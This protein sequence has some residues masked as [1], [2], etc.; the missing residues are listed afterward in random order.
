MIDDCPANGEGA[1]FYLQAFR[2]K[3]VLITGGLGFIGSNL[4]R[5][6]LDLGAEVLIVDSLIPEYGGNLFNVA[7]FADRVRINIADVRDRSSMD[8]LVQGQDYLFN[9][10]GQVS[11]LDSMKDPFTDLE[12]NCRSQ[13]SILESCRYNNPGVKVVFASTR[14]IYG[15]P[16]YLPVDERHLLHPTDVNGINKMAGEWYHIVYNNAYGLRATSLRLTNTFGPG[17]RAR[18]ARQTFLGLWLRLAV[19]GRELAIYGD[20]RQVRD[21]NYVDDVVDALLRAAADELANGQVYN[22]GGDEPIDLLH[23]A[24]LLVE[25]AGKGSYRLVPWPDNR[26]RID[27][28]DY[29]GDYRKIRSKLGWCPRVSL[30][31]GLR[32]TLRFYEEHGQHYWEEE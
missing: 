12:I 13:L 19:Q 20:G 29:Y 9:L 7:A 18:D 6:L 3:R 31:E 5:T 32:R 23:L 14:Q 21:F 2:G 17:M 10:A 28:G 26:K 11:H 1:P 15:V 16:D 4:A 30:A 25:L 27:I 22:L 8:Y 24:R